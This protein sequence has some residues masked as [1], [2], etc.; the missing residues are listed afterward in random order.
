MRGS[1]TQIRAGIKIKACNMGI[2]RLVRLA[3]IGNIKLRRPHFGKR[4]GQT[5][6]HV[7]KFIQILHQ[8][9]PEV[10]DIFFGIHNGR[11]QQ[12]FA[13]PGAW[14]TRTCYHFFV[15][16]LRQIDASQ[17]RMDASKQI[18]R[19]VKIRTKFYRPVK[20]R[21][22][23]VQTPAS[24]MSIA[25]VELHFRI[26]RRQSL[27]NLIGLER[28]FVLTDVRKRIG[29]VHVIGSNCRLLNGRAP[30]IIDAGCTVASLK[31]RYP[32]QMKSVGMCGLDFERLAI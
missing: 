4:I 7:G 24:A 16:S 15:A 8:T 28:L 5:Q 30:Q 9:L 3:V 29:E 10:L 27:C 26:L 20:S 25:D 21:D 23:L 31:Q 19:L 12:R 22:S 13:N 14:I 6:A 18:K 32:Q 2:E 17:F 11:Q 1:P